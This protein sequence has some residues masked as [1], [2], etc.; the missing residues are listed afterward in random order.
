MAHLTDYQTVTDCRSIIC[1]GRLPC[2]DAVT[3]FRK[4]YEGYPPTDIRLLEY[5]VE[6]APAAL[7]LVVRVLSH[8]S[9]GTRLLTPLLSLYY[10]AK[11]RRLVAQIALFLSRIYHNS[12][13]AAE[14]LRH[15]ESRVRANVLEGLRTWNHDLS[16]SRRAT[17]DPN[18]RV[19]VNACLNLFHGGDPR[20]RHMLEGFL[21]DRR[22]EF[23]TA[24]CWGLGTIAA[25]EDGP[26][27]E[28]LLSDEHPAVRSH[29][30]RVL[31]RVKAA[32]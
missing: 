10:N 29:A 7:P 28:A 4:L 3:L 9:D 5:A 14:A 31:R 20:G 2:R 21:K 30:A 25:P 19:A 27:F 8:V 6:N 15:P 17:C 23:R 26:I 11:E 1:S 22:N 13:W 12:E 16:L 24:A 32:A 18:H